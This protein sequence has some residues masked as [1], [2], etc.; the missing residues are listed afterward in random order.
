MLQGCP[1]GCR[2]HKALTTKRAIR[3]MPEGRE[4]GRREG[5]ERGAE[6]FLQRIPQ[7]RRMK[8]GAGESCGG[9]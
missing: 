2:L 1:P 9:G 6:T 5:G 7:G 4:G 8:R 3:K